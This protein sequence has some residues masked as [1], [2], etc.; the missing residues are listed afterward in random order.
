MRNLIPGA[1]LSLP[2]TYT[3]VSLRQRAVIKQSLE[4]GPCLAA[5]LGFGG[6]RGTKSSTWHCRV[7]KAPADK[8]VTK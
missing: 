5:L 1:P 3:L 2:H 6:T 4:H 8:T 7:S